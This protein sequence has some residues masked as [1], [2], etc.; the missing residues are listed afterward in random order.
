M[1]SII[2]ANAHEEIIAAVPFS[3]GWGGAH[4]RHISSG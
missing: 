4:L 3:F 2:P 1:S